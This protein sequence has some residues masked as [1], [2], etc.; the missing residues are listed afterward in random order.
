MCKGDLIA[1]AADLYSV[2]AHAIP[3]AAISLQSVPCKEN[4]TKHTSHITHCVAVLQ[5]CVLKRSGGRLNS[6]TLRHVRCDAQQ[7]HITSNVS[8][9]CG[10]VNGKFYLATKSSELHDPIKTTC[11]TMMTLTGSLL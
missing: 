8:S 6:F 1:V 4:L 7:Q 11:S 9:D 2:G 3:V 10:D 5:G